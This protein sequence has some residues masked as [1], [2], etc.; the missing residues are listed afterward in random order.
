MCV[1]DVYSPC[2]EQRSV[3]GAPK[4]HHFLALSGTDGGRCSVMEKSWTSDSRLLCYSGWAAALWAGSVSSSQSV[5]SSDG[6]KASTEISLSCKTAAHE[7]SPNPRTALIAFK[8]VS[9]SGKF[10]FFK[11]LGIA[12]RLVKVDAL[13]AEKQQKSEIVLFSGENSKPVCTEKNKMIS[14]KG[15][16]TQL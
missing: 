5:C 11:I 10:T 4:E 14:L 3:C 1:L 16:R 15:C 7:S 9:E 2:S 12:P 13:I 8:A 6:T